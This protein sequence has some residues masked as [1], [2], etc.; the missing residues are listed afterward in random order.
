MFVGQL[1]ISRQCLGAGQG[2]VG[3][4]EAKGIVGG[5]DVEAEPGVLAGV[6]RLARQR[7]NAGGLP[8]ADGEFLIRAILALPPVPQRGHRALDHLLVFFGRASGFVDEFPRA[9][10]TMRGEKLMGFGGIE[11]GLRLPGD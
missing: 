3:V 9:I 11:V 5:G 4:G 2:F 10:E 7:V 8:V 1:S 6:V